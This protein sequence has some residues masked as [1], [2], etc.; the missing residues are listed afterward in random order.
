MLRFRLF[1]IPFEVDPTFWI[2]SAILGANAAH[3]SNWLLLLAVWVACVF[4]SIV[5]HEMGHAQAARHY[6]AS[7]TVR[8]Y[9]MG[10]LTRPGQAFS[11]GQ[12]LIVVL[13]GPAAGFALYLVVRA[14]IYYAVTSAPAADDFLA[15]DSPGSLA[16]AQA[17]HDL[18]FINLVWTLFNLLPV[19]P[20]DGGLILLGVLGYGRVG[21]ARIIGTVCA[22]GCAVWAYSVGQTYTAF[23]FGYLA[24]QNIQAGAGR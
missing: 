5:V 10:G 23:F 12:N 15:G 11:R 1:G 18:S 13:C 7:P 19:L 21:L 14:F 22:G 20:L 9:A 16:A 6:G 24:L 2:F 4:V 3:G 17:L 8:L